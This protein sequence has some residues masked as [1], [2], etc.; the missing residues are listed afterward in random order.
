MYLFI[1]KHICPLFQGPHFE[2]WRQESLA[3]AFWDVCLGL[4]ED[5][6]DVKIYTYSNIFGIFHDIGTSCA[7]AVVLG[8]R[9]FTWLENKTFVERGAMQF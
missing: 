2:A 7:L 3:V 9:C 6:V 8:H 5:C 1:R 4:S